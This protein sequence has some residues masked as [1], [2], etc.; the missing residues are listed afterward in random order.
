MNKYHILVID[1]DERLRDLLKQYLTQNGFL[2]SVACD[3]RE[4]RRQLK[5]Y[6]FDFMVVDVMMPGETGFEFVTS[7]RKEQNKTP[8][9]MLTAMGEVDDRIKGLEQGADDYLAKPFEPKELLL[10]LNNILNRVSNNKDVC[11]FGEF[12]FEFSSLKLKKNNKFIHLTESEGK[13]LLVFCKH[14][15]EI[16]NREKICEL[17]DDIDERSVDVQVVRLRKKIEIDSKKPQ[18]LQTLRGKGYIL[19]S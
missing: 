7:I 13:L 15:G 1:D 9:L 16:I 2:V 10:R 6:I 19:N 18:Y 5:K 4:A 17:Y 12:L 3:V 11:E 14:L 8:V